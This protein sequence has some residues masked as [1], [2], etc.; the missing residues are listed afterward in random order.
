MKHTQK[1]LFGICIVVIGAFMLTACSK[2]DKEDPKP[3]DPVEKTGTVS[4]TIWFEDTDETIQFKGYGAGSFASG[5]NGDTVAVGFSDNDSPMTFFFMLT[6]AKKG[7]HIMG[8]N[9][10]FSIGMFQKDSTV[11]NLDKTYLLGWDNF[12]PEDEVEDAA[13]FNITSVS[14]DRIK[15]TFTTTM[16]SNSTVKENGEI[17]SGEIKTVT[18]TNGAFDVPLISE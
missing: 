7:K 18:V 1:L 12:D 2:K 3:T 9:G 6:P 10:F 14:K 11:T 8:K 5:S 4:A 13:T 17:I 16:I 15:G